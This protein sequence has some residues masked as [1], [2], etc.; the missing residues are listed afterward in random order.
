MKQL[1]LASGNAGKL[2]E[3]R[4]ML[5]DLPLRIVAQGELGVDDV[6]ETGLTFVENALIKARHASAVTGLPALADD[7]GL[8]VDAL[9]GAP[10]LYSARYAGSPTDA[11][12]NNAK[13]LDAMRAVPAE[14]RSA[15]FYAVIVLLRHPEDPQPLIAEG[16]WEGVITTEPR[17]TGGFGYNPVFLDPLHGLTAAEMDTA[18][19]NRLS[20]RAVAL[21]TLQHKLHALSL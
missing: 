17:G 5:A 16:S 8:I 14:R 7:S 21:A 6:P 19:K 13:L 3:L 2:E 11:Q 12:A 20:H 18:L 4:A 9:G 10:G 1:V 15:R